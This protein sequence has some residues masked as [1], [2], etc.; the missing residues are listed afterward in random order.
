[1]V[2]AFFDRRDAGMT[3]Q[4]QLRGLCVNDAETI[5]RVLT[6]KYLL[7]LA[8]QSDNSTVILNDKLCINVLYKGGNTITVRCG[9]VIGEPNGR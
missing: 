3:I 7:E 6:V 5:W 9:K 1:M 2:A 8:K 4:F